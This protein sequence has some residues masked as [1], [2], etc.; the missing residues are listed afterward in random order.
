MAK[1]R[2]TVPITQRALIQRINRVLARDGQ[3]L[4]A[5]R[6]G[7][8]E[9]DLGRYYIVDL[10]RNRLLRGDVELDDL[11]RELDVIAGYE[12]LEEGEGRSNHD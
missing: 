2:S 9:S 7:K 5:Y 8:W 3:Q 11:G 1:T 4:K 10:N 6:G 12:K